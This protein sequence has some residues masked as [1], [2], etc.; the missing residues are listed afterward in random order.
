MHNMA[1]IYD[2]PFSYLLCKKYVS[3]T[4]KKFYSEYIILGSENIPES[5]PVLFAPNHLNALMDALAVLTLTND[6]YSLVFLA[7]ADLFRK[8]TLAQILHFF[9]IMP[10]FRMRDGYENLGK[11]EAVFNEGIEVLELKNT[12]CI[13]PEG[14]QELERKLRPL[15]KGIFRIAF[16]A[17]EKLADSADVK[18][19]PIGLDMGSLEKSNAHLII[20]LGQPISVSEYMNEY[21]ENQ[22]VATN[23][24]KDELSNRLSNI[25]LN[26]NTEKY[27]DCFEKTTRICNFQI[28]NDLG[29]T[30]ST[31]HR[32]Y[33]RQE[34]AKRLVELERTDEDQIIKLE[35]LVQNFEK[36]RTDL[37]LHVNNF[38]DES[39]NT[40]ANLLKS[41]G[42]LVTLPVFIAGF[43]LN[44]FAFFSPVF[45]RKKLHVEFTGFFTSIQYALSLFTFPIFYLL[46]TSLI[47]SL[48]DISW[49]TAMFIIP[50]HYM[51][52]KWSIQLYK[53][54][55][56]YL[57][58]LHYKKVQKTDSKEFKN[59]VR[60]REEIIHIV[61]TKKG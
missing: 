61:Q 58:Y 17:Q 60:L 27:Y 31:V 26:L 32:F 29:L 3:W 23:K 41:I 52:G 57:G 43:L 49:W 25:T 39:K 42:L 50:I 22:A 40:S 28:M 4:F 36:L 8:K 1:K 12:M 21:Q 51:F 48:F 9:K 34:I 30:D 13:M 24:I 55:R 59:I 16:A 6:R 11:N 45:I 47:I 7:R 44:F 15:V 20:S 35:G 5:G 14:N 56:K 33:A 2:L 46:Q 10:A 19:I 18:I 53:T 37:K 54:Y 38:D